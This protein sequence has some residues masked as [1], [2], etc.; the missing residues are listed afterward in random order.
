MT[1]LGTSSQAATEYVV[2]VPK[3]TSKKYNIMAFNA[4][5]KVNFATWHQAKM[6]RDLSNKKIYQ[7]EEMPESGAGSEF[8]RKLR[9]EARRKKYGII[10]KE[11]KPEDQPW[12]LKVNGKAGRKF[13]GVK[14]GGVTENTSY[15]IFTQ[16][17]DGAFEAFPVN[18][19]YNFTPIA[20]HRTLTAEEAEEE[21]ERRNKVLNHFS[22]MQQRRLK[23][24]GEEEEEEKEK[25]GKKKGSDLKI[26]DLED[27]LEMS[28]DDSE[29]SDADGEKPTK[30]KK[31]APLTKKKKKKKGSD[32]EAFEDSDD[33]D[34]E[35]QEV[36]YMSDGSSS[37]EEVVGKPKT[38]N[39][40]DIPK[41]IDEA[42]E[43]SEESE[44]EKPA[45]EK[46]EEEEEKKVPTPQDKKKKKDSS[47]ESE[48]SEDSDIDSEAS[49]ALFMT[50]KKTPPKKERKGSA[51]SS[52]GNSRPGTPLVD[53]SSTSST[54]RA[55]AN[56]LEQG[57]RQGGSGEFPA[58]K[59]LKLESGNQAATTSGKSTPQPQ[60]GKSTPNSGDVQ[61]TEDAVRRYLT[62]K[63]MTTKDLLKKFQTKK[64]GLSSDQTVNVLA[65]ILKRLNPERKNINDKMHF[66]L[67]E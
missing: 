8:N 52:Q 59:R 7:E 48:T 35:G 13:K 47:D 46:E 44:E 23:D 38:T 4:A 1:S 24:Q 36:D 18:N 20:K 6:E 42:S 50:K 67:K 34:F 64:T 57:K 17:P 49:S 19:W 12:I 11:F 62:R 66:F 26:H 60:S 33:G 56:K 40:E 43:S 5:D 3:N 15:Y 45:E 16:C 58:A 53:A 31:K 41:G 22:I 39:E 30:P 61:L 2:R 29:F 27:D 21:W 37:V 51:S 14:K 25:K 9:E 28:S 32:D 63:P 54:L 65:Q 10:L 55:A